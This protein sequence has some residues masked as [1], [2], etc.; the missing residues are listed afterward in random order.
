MQ[1]SQMLGKICRW[2]ANCRDYRVRDAHTR[3]T[4]GRIPVTQGAN[5]LEGVS[6]SSL[7]AGSVHDVATRNHHYRIEYLGGDKARISGHPR[8]CP[9][10]V[11]VQVEGSIGRSIETGFI[12]QGMHLVFRPLDDPRPVTTSEITEV[13][14]V[15]P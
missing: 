12:G 1:L 9:K 14:V 15:E 11:E 3:E 10:P 4:R 2:K 13:S 5:V 8:L 6:L 7:Q